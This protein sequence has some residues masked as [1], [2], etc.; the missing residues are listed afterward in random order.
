MLV[1]RDSHSSSRSH[2]A[3]SESAMIHHAI[4]VVFSLVALLHV[5]SM[6]LAAEHR[7]CHGG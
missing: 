7:A 1:D 5:T 6:A 3:V 2:T 4:K